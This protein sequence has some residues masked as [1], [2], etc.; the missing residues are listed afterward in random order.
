M[1]LLRFVAFTAR[2]VE[3]VSK[4]GKIA[5]FFIAEIVVSFQLIRRYHYSI[6]NL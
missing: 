6:G 1:S 3:S 4:F 5:I 2:F